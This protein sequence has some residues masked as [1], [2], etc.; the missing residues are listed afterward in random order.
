MAAGVIIIILFRRN[1][2]A[3]IIKRRVSIGANEYTLSIAFIDDYQRAADGGD[4]NE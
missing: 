1:E 4:F 2:E 3:A